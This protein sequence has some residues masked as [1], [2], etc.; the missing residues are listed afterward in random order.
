MSISGFKRTLIALIP[1]GVL[2]VLLVLNISVFGA[3][4]ILGPSQVVLL[5]ASG[6]C[7]ALSMWL[8]KT[9][10]KEFEKAISG[11]VGDVAGAILILFLIGAIS[12]TWTMSG[13]VPAFICYGIK[14]ISPKVFLLTACVLC[15][16]VS[17][18]TGSSW[19]V[20]ATVGV[21]LLGIGRAEGFSDAMTAGAII[22]G[23]YFGDKISPLSDTTVL[24][25]SIN[26]VNL[27]EH[28]HYMYYTTIPSFVITLIIFTVLGLTHGGA[29]AGE[30]EVYTSTL[31]SRFN[32][33]PLLMLVPIITVILIWR[34]LPA[35]MVLS[36][37]ALVAAAA[38]LI[39][40][41]GIV[42][43]IGRSVT[44]GS[45]VKVYFAG[46]VEMVYNT[47]SLDTGNADVN[48][49]VTSR[50]MLGMLNTVYLIICA[51]CFGACM[52]ASGMIADLS[53]I[54]APL[55]RTRTGLVAS[56]VLT[57]TALNGIVS[58]QYL[59]II[60]T[61]NIYRDKFEKDGYEP[62]L[63]SRSVEDSATVTSPLF[64]WSSCGMTQATI[65]S[66]PT[67]LYAPFCFFCLLSPLMSILI[68]AIGWKI[69][70]HKQSS[71]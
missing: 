13:V 36:I 23:A 44:S 14:I 31:Q 6:V 1:L 47:V 66:V 5:V 67:L 69:R 59:A 62:R 8:Y 4:S 70:R 10:W 33:T 52:K 2:I 25:S 63:L 15:A 50:G 12:G 20:I 38:A 54:L 56:T 45:P 24:A 58:D 19:T 60:L 51:M 28:I 57:G 48:R 34:R 3:D 30:M 65:L 26:K 17:V 35:L 32:I 61:S 27:F 43:E 71:L 42:D 16:V 39:F 21:A 55:T 41:T 68:G 18:M 46:V 40:Q 49:L 22:S 9:P 53:R 7:V 37:S 29:S 11:N 64:P